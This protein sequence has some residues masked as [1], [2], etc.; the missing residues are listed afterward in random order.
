MI[1]ISKGRYWDK[2]LSL[3]DGCT[4]CSPGCENCW[5]MAM[6]KRFKRW[7][8]RV[9]IRPDRFTIPQKTRKP[10]IFAAWNDL[11]HEDVPDEFIL[12]AFR[13]M[14]GAFWHTYL[15][16][17]K[18][19]H[20]AKAVIEKNNPFLRRDG[21][22]PFGPIWEHTWLGVTV[23]NQQEADEKIPLLLQTP[24]A[25]RWISIEP[26]LGP[27]D[28]SNI[29]IIVGAGD[30]RSFADIDAVILGAETGPHARP[31]HPN[32]VRSIRNQCQ[33]DGV[34]F[35]FKQWGEWLPFKQADIAQMS[36]INRRKKEKSYYWG[37]GEYSHKI[38][39]AGRI[40]DGRTHDELPWRMN[41]AG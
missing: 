6:G 30:L 32:W 31:I 15:I 27:I 20:R 10:T 17:T 41:N 21:R 35:F 19:P 28:L 22:S 38:E 13:T 7:P 29:C 39:K 26:M 23:C 2:P 14:G 36:A 18:R 25:H 12:Q 16:L 3:V 11:F 40:L 1:D 24:A 4:P 34:P 8:D 37:G 33:A 9:T 5:S